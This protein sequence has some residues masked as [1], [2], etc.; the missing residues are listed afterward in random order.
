MMVGIGFVIKHTP[1]ARPCQPRTVLPKLGSPMSRL[2]VVL[3]SLASL[4]L[5]L[6]AGGAF[7]EAGPLI[8]APRPEVFSFSPLPRWYSVIFAMGIVGAY[9]LMR[10][11]WL[12]D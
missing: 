9:Y 3:A 7:A 4:L 8:W 12:R 1:A 11:L 5:F 10:R 2:H 6:P